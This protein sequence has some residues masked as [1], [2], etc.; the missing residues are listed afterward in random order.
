MQNIRPTQS[1]WAICEYFALKWASIL[2]FEADSHLTTAVRRSVL[3]G[4]E[5][6]KIFCNT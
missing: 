6:D 5:K 4:S 2:S 1:L 3:R